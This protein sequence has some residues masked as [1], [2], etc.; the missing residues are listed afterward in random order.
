MCCAYCFPRTHAYCTEC[1][2]NV[3][4]KGITDVIRHLKLGGCGSATHSTAAHPKGT[5]S[6]DASHRRHGAA[7]RAHGSS[8]K[9]AMRDLIASDMLS[10]R[11]MHKAR[12]VGVRITPG[13]PTGAA[14]PLACLSPISFFTT[15]KI[16]S[17][18][19]VGKAERPVK[20][21]LP[22]KNQNRQPE[23]SVLI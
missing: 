19:G 12:P 7:R 6:G 14:A 4:I 20:T 10:R 11:G 1:G 16:W 21:Y 15:R 3:G 5:S 8:A 2:E 17:P 18:K 13:D 9:H 23:L 22:K